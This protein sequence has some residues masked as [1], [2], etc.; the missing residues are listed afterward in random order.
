[1]FV[2]STAFNFNIVAICVDS[3]AVKLP[4]ATACSN[5]ARVICF[6]TATCPCSV[7]I[8]PAFLNNSSASAFATPFLVA[9]SIISACVNVFVAVVNPAFAIA[10]STSFAVA[11]LII[12]ICL[13]CSSVAPLLANANTDCSTLNPFNAFLYV[14]TFVIFIPTIL[15][16]NAS[17]DFRALPS[18]FKSLII[19]GICLNIALLF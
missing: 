4:F 6:L 17:N 16:F 15:I 7:A 3:A 11:S 2:L 19:V 9:I 13:I 12:N 10:G 8:I 1:M 18:F 5:I 14:S